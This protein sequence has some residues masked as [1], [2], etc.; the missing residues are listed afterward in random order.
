VVIIALDISPIKAKRDRMVSD[1]FV[2]GVVQVH[3]GRV[4]TFRLAAVLF[5]IWLK[6]LT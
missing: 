4:V 1:D 3:V 6:V 5:E 2:R